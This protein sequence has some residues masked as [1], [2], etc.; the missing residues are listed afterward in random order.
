MVTFAEN[1][2]AHSDHTF[3][4][5]IRKIFVRNIDTFINYYG[6]NL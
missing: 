2:I 4:E 1:I 6:V 5:G 3:R